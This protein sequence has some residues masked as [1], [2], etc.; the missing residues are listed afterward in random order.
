MSVA[1]FRLKRLLSFCRPKRPRLFPP[2]A[3]EPIGY[4]EQRAVNHG[5]V[6]TCQLHHASFDNEAA[7]LDE[8]PRALAALDLPRAHVMSRPCGLMPVARCSVA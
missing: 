5:T 1:G 4:P 3:L 2:I 7:K 8:V 6:V